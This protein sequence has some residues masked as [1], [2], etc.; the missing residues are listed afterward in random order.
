MENAEI[1]NETL[2]AFDC[3]N[4]GAGLKYKPGTTTLICE[5]CN[6]KNIIPQEQTIIEENDFVT[7]LEKLESEN[8]VVE[9]T[10]QCKSCGAASTININ[11]KSSDCPYCNTPLIDA[12]TKEDRTIKPQYLL[13]FKIDK[14]KAALLGYNW[15]KDTWFTKQIQSSSIDLS[16]VYV[17][18]WTFDVQTNSNYNVER[19]QVN[20]NNTYLQS[21]SG[22][23]SLFF[24]DIVV[25]ASGTVDTNLLAKVGPWI[26]KN[27]VNTNDQ[28]LSDYI[29]EKHKLGLKQG[30]YVG[31]KAIDETISKQINSQVGS[32]SNTK[33]KSIQS[34]YNNIKFKH[35]LLPLYVATYEY[36]GQK[37]IFYIN[38]NTGAVAGVRPKSPINVFL[39]KV[40]IVIFIIVGILLL[41]VFLLA[42][43]GAS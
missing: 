26:T 3:S 40:A 20:G 4:C 33:V 25:P 5:Y 8:S 35:I 32:G 12:S 2:K 17:P 43:L 9:E 22:N 1:K 27:L 41:L 36:K 6:T 15:A 23:L 7:Y 18:H 38:G 42:W 29:V 14:Q 10:L 13:P 11:S 24:D 31:K 16:G 19:K 21:M 37:N 39:K 30:F 34:Q 28:Y